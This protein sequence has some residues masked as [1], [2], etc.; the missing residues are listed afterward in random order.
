MPL[1]AS[2]FDRCFTKAN[3]FRFSRARWPW[4]FLFRASFCACSA[5]SRSF[6]ACRSRF[7]IF[8]LSMA[9]A[10]S[11]SSLSAA[12]LAS[13]RLLRRTRPVPGGP[14]PRLSRR[15]AYACSVKESRL[16]RVIRITRTSGRFFTVSTTS[17]SI[18]PRAGCG[19]VPST[20]TPLSSVERNAS[21]NLRESSSIF[22]TSSQTQRRGRGCSSSESES[23]G[24]LG[25]FQPS[26]TGCSFVSSTCSSCPVKG[27]RILH[28]RGAFLFSSLFSPPWFFSSSLLLLSL[29][30]LLLSPLA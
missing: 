10:F 28:M 2:S 11:F 8:S 14:R 19:I 27:R 7:A 15:N 6:A 3:A 20:D 21:G 24:S 5:R 18:W 26:G 1:F 9:S 25:G 4:I 22:P 12:S 29:L 23:S 30:L 17:E 13:F 16:L